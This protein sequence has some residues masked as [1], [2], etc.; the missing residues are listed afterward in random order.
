MLLLHSKFLTTF[1]VLIEFIVPKMLDRFGKLFQNRFL[2]EFN[3]NGQTL[4]KW[5]RHR[6]E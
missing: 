2:S 3:M 4:R 5:K 6:F 1:E